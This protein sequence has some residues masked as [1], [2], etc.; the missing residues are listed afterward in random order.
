MTVWS[1]L[2][3]GVVQP[4]VWSSRVVQPPVWSSLKREL[5][6]LM[7]NTSGCMVQAPEA[8]YIPTSGRMS[9]PTFGV[10]SG[11]AKDPLWKHVAMENTGFGVKQE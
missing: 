3:F 9:C 8:E 1:S 10:R 7:R 5:D 4:P 6:G 11:R 2:S